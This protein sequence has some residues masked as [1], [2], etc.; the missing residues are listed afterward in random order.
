MAQDTIAVLKR[1][2]NELDQHKKSKKELLSQ[3]I[4]TRLDLSLKNYYEDL[5]KAYDAITRKDAAKVIKRAFSKE[6]K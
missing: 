6:K 5:M 3:Y 4:Q 2:I 1:M